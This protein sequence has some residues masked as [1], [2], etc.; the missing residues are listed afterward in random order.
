MRLRLNFYLAIIIPLAAACANQHL[1]T[2]SDYLKLVDNSFNERK[3]LAANRS[4]EL[5]TVFKRSLSVE[6]KEA[7]KF[8]YAFM[9]LSDLADYDGDFFL[10]NIDPS[11]RA[12]NE[13]PWGSN[14]PVEIFLHYILPCRVNNENLD[15]FRIVY[16]DEI[17]SRIRNQN[18]IS[19]AM[20]INHWCHEKVNYQA[21]DIRTS[22][23]MSTILSARGRCGEESTFTVAALRTAGIPARQVYTPR[24][25]H[26]DDNHAWVEVW[27]DGEWYYMGA[28][29]PEAVIDRGWFTEPARRAMLIH[30]K[31]LGASL[32]SENTVNRYKHYT[33]VN[34]LSKY[35]VTKRIFI[36][37]T[38]QNN[39]PVHGARVE[40]KLFNYA[41]FYPLAIVP[42][43]TNGVSQF[44]TGFG[45]LLIWASDNDAFTYRKISVAETDTL[46]LVL[47]KKAGG[48]YSI[49]L[50]LDV[51]LTPSPYPGLSSALTE[52]NTNRLNAENEIR[53]QYIDS[54][55]KPD[56]AKSFAFERNL[57]TARTTKIIARSMGNYKEICSFLSDIPD[58]L[59]IVAI[60]M[61]ELLPDKDLRDTR[62][63]DLSDHLMNTDNSIEKTHYGDKIFLEYLLNPRIAN[64]IITSWRSYFLNNLPDDL[65]QTSPADPLLVSEYLEKNIRI[66]D[67]ENYY[68]TPL[69]PIGVCDLKVSD[70]FS[71]DICFV[72]IC[73]SLGIPSRLEPGTNQPQYFLNSVWNDLFFSDKKKPSGSKSYLKLVSYDTD[74]VPEYY[75]HFTLAKFDNGSYTTMQY[76]YNKK[77]TDFSEIALAPGSYLLVTGNRLASGRILSSL[78]FFDLSEGEHKTAEIKIRKDITGGKL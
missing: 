18:I 35:A 7:L 23:P 48:F 34:N 13:T 30:T 39:K 8:L 53:T 63:A 3:V 38:G 67:D 58:S 71:R 21:A 28:C 4:D 16:Y 66:A 9:P 19:A 10:A 29:E 54:W 1:I 44:E 50:D 15:S 60:S 31:S 59:S 42:T 65:T 17:M 41:E 55:I 75:L 32:K 45:D 26:T 24:W 47:D 43:D 72:A 2:D 64:E 56:E 37:V 46:S 33:E 68:R 78:L 52:S 70:S 27:S 5:F 69:T 61:L 14:I 76:D 74:P 57:D 25:A 62:A 11:L 36:R 77:I 51:P 49:D 73:R 20:E 40:Y 12:R 22:S 6:Q